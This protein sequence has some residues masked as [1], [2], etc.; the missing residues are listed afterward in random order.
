MSVFSRFTNTAKMEKKSKMKYL[1]I[2]AIYACFLAD[3]IFLFTRHFL[4]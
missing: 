4:C 3:K 1:K 2:K